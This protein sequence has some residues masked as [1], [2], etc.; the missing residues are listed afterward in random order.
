MDHKQY[1]KT[2]KEYRQRSGH[3]INYYDGGASRGPVREEMSRKK[4]KQE[5]LSD[6]DR[7][8]GGR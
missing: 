6:R 5:R 4:M 8:V 1:V 2:V 3:A 7:L